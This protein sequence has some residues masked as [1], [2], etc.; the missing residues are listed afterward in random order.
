MSAITYAEL[1]YGASVSA[2]PE[3]EHDNLVSLVEDIQ[4]VPF[5]AA[6]ETANH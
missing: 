1:E 2:N 4:V 5:D 3:Q 6:A